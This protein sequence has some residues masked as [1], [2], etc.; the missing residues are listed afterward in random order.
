M[1]ALE[2]LRILRSKDRVLRRWMKMIGILVML[3]SV[4]F[5]FRN[6]TLTASDDWFFGFC[7]VIGFLTFIIGWLPSKEDKDVQ[8]NAISQYMKEG[9]RE[10]DRS[11]EAPSE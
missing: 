5:I 2:K 6:F 9:V 4:F 3:V 10:K 8:K 1:N 11:Q 7:A